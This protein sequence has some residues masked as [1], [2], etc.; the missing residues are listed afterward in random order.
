MMVSS[1]NEISMEFHGIVMSVLDMYT[2]DCV[3]R[4]ANASWTFISLCMVKKHEHKKGNL[5]DQEYKAN[6]MTKALHAKSISAATIIKKGSAD[7]LSFTELISRSIAQPKQSVFF[8]NSACKGP[9]TI[10]PRT[11]RVEHHFATSPEPH[12]PDTQC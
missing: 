3:P 5:I 2:C 11:K 10:Q 9:M 12:L 1:D 4:G 8:K 7:L 6:Y